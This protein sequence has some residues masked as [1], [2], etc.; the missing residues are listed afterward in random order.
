MKKQ[1]IFLV[2]F[3][4][5]DDDGEHRSTDIISGTTEEECYQV[6]YQDIL[7]DFP[8]FEEE[9]KI[10]QSI[11]FIKGGIIDYKKEVKK[12]S[13]IIEEQECG[14]IETDDLTLEVEISNNVVGKVK[15]IR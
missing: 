1:S 8:D 7:G 4:K 12:M 11:D 5:F 2:M 15:V 9:F 14:R 13:R 10:P 3:Q 6:I